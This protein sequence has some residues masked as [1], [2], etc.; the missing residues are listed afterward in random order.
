MS[1]QEPVPVKV[2]LLRRRPQGEGRRVWRSL[3]EL[4]ESDAFREALER[5]FPAQASEW[6]D[7]EGRRHF[8]KMMGASLALAGLAGC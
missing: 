4:A 1:G 7:P 5:E 6:D 3:E 8:M 2:E